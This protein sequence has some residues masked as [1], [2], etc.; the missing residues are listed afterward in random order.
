MYNA[1]G[2]QQSPYQASNASNDRMYGQ[3]GP[4]PKN[5]MGPPSNRHG[6]PGQHGEHHE[7]KPNGVMHPEQGGQGHDEEGD[8]DHDAEYTHNSA[9]Y[10]ASRSSY[11]YTAPSIGALSNDANINPDMAGSPGHPSASGRA[12]PRTAAPHQ[13]YYPQNS[14]YNTPPRVQQSTSNLYNVVSNDRGPANGAHGGD[15][16]GSGADMS[17]PMP[18]GYA[19]QPPMMNGAA[20]GM[21]RGRD[22]E[23]DMAQHGSDGPGGMGNLDLKRRKTMMET[24]VPAP[25]YD[26]LNR[27][28][29]AIAAPRRR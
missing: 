22:E 13:S 8:H 7:T 3:P 2:S 9:A 16:Y 28:A 20:G 23:D 5:D 27:P 12:T 10:D 4:Y 29:S 18:N 19:P 6:G 25:A 17:N 1:T 11:N 14:G 26:A 15:V 24:S 21:K